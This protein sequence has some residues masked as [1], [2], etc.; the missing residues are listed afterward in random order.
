[1]K[2]NLHKTKGNQHETK[3]NQ[4][5]TKKNQQAARIDPEHV[6]QARQARRDKKAV[7]D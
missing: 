6:R 3:G 5:K 1:L 2:G 7:K 4:R